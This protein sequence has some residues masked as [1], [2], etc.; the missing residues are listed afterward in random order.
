MSPEEFLEWVVSRYGSFESIP[1]H[2]FKSKWKKITDEIAPHYF[3][4]VPKALEETFP[5]EDEEVFNYRIKT[6]QPKTE[7]CIT[8][9]INKL[10]RLLQDSKFHIRYDNENMERF[11]KQEKKVEGERI[12]DFFISKFVSKR[13]LDPNGVFLP[14][15]KGPGLTNN[16][17]PIDFDLQFI[18]S[19]QIKFIDFD[20]KLLIYRGPSREKY[21]PTLTDATVV[22]EFYDYVVT[23]TF[24]GVII[25]KIETGPDNKPVRSSTLKVIYE[26]DL[27]G[28]VPFIVM[29]GRPLT[30]KDHGYSFTYYKSDLSSAIPFL[31]DAATSDN[32]EKS[33]INANCFPVKIMQGIECPTCKGNKTMKVTTEKH[34]DGIKVECDTCKGRGEIFHNSPLKGI[35]IKPKKTI[36]DKGDSNNEKP[37]EF[38]SPNVDTIRHVGDYAEKKFK[39]AKEVLNIDKAVKF[40]QS[41]VAKEIDNEP[42]YIEIKRISDDVFFKMQYLLEVLQGLRFMDNTGKIAVISPTSFDIKSELEL[43][44]EF[45]ATLESKSPDFVRAAAFEE[46]MKAKFSTDEVGQRIANICVSYAPLY[47]YTVEE[48]EMMFLTKTATQNDMV[49][50]TYVLNELLKFNIDDPNFIFQ[51]FDIVAA[52]LDE[53]LKPRFE[54]EGEESPPDVVIEEEEPEGEPTGDE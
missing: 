50:A 54:V 20:L 10:S 43:F 1:T 4:R 30:E 48:R 16:Q 32:Q 23:D 35:Y 12:T 22:D 24:C 29:G 41:G 14:F 46:W 37:I 52:A 51:D 21:P 34:P 15:P 26:Y 36:K 42:D 9:A 5:N 7:A 25:P 33:V 17:I 38:V 18:E 49:R 53:A 6:Y 40:A 31:N 13:M 19:E 47:L 45:K 28:K 2:P 39:E 27:G 3:G 11:I 8:D 44:A